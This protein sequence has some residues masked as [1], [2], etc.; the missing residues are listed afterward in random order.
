M[1]K[2]IASIIGGLVVAFALVFFSDAVFHALSPTSAPS[3]FNDTDAMRRYVESQPVSL[4]VGVVF[5]WAV[6]ALAGSLL[7][8]RYGGRGGWPGWV[9]T[10][11]FLLATSTNFLMVPHPTWMIAIAILLIAA[12]GWLGSRLGAKTAQSDAMPSDI[13]G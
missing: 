8:A 10:A 9:V 1:L 2:L 7:A 3:D 6:A 4:L 13:E 5:G 11:L 12:A